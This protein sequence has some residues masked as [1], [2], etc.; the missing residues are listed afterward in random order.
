MGRDGV[1]CGSGVGLRNA[2]SERAS[3]N[4]I[5]EQHIWTSLNPD[6][7]AFVCSIER[8]HVFTYSLFAR[9]YLSVHFV[10]F[11]RLSDSGKGLD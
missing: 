10:D 7:I 5:T 8:T 3:S 2:T 4:H 11:H 6:R 9:S 1:K